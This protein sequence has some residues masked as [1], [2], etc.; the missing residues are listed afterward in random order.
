MPFGCIITRRSNCGVNGEGLDMNYGTVVT[1]TLYT[2]LT[3]GGQV[4]L[5]NLVNYAFIDSY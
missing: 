1:G 2:G 4:N 3:S 5:E